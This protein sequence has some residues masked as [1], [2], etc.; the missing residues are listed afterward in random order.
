MHIVFVKNRKAFTLQTLKLYFVYTSALICH[1]FLSMFN[2]WPKSQR[3]YGMECYKLGRYARSLCEKRAFRFCV[4]KVAFLKVFKTG[5][6]LFWV[7]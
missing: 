5:K 7:L 1:Y 2:K 3:N 6:Y 4:V